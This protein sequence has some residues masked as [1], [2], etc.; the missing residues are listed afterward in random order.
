M[1]GILSAAFGDKPQA[2]IHTETAEYISLLR[3][4]RYDRHNRYRTTSATSQPLQ[5]ASR[6][7]GRS[8]VYDTST[9]RAE[10]PL[11]D[12]PIRE[13]RPKSAAELG[14]A[15]LHPDRLRA[16]VYRRPDRCGTC[17]CPWSLLP[18]NKPAVPLIGARDWH[19]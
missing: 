6:T 3:Y 13:G 2:A 17:E 5:L 8:G 11:A 9:F 18:E 10:Q 12:R 16:Y 14:Q 7:A 15:S 4:T 1:Y 19:C